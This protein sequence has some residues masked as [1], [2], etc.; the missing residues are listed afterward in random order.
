MR[1]SDWSSDVCSSDLLKEALGDHVHIVEERLFTSPDPLALQHCERMSALYRQPRWLRMLTGDRLTWA[2][3]TR[4]INPKA[5]LH[6]SVI[7]RLSAAAVPQMGTV[8]P[9][10]PDRKSTRLNSSH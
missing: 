7:E 1:I 10:R 5:P 8:K 3:L 2:K 4:P 6:P 9:Y